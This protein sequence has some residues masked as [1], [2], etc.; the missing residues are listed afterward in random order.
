MLNR[1]SRSTTF[2]YI[3]AAIDE[4]S[5]PTDEQIALIRLTLEG[6]KMTYLDR[7]EQEKLLNLHKA[8]IMSG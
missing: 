4:M 6:R 7:F 5:L 2:Q 3:G 1:S 8:N